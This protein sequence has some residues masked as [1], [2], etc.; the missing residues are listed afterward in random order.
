LKKAAA[1]SKIV[2]ATAETI[3]GG[4]QFCRT[5]SRAVEAVFGSEGGQHLRNR[6]SQ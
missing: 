6:L 4:F 1:V 5:G 3:D 2:R